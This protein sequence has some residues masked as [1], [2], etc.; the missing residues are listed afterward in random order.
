MP[1]AQQLVRTAVT[2]ITDTETL[3]LRQALGRILA[4][5][6]VS[7]IAVPSHDNSAMDGYA[8]R[9]RAGYTH[10]ASLASSDPNYWYRYVAMDVLIPF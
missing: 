4:S 7:P 3:P 6:L 5:E 8:L 10:A 9:M 1:L 2:P